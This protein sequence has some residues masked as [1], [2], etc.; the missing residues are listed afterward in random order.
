MSDGYMQIYEGEW[1]EPPKRGFTNQCCA[2]G[3]VHVFDFVV[4]DRR[5]GEK[6]P[7]TKI[8]F[9]LKVDRRKTAALRRKFKFT[10]DSDD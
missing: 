5:T 8:Q 6:L 10:K 1:I 3:L 7:G 9:R 4:I 2:C